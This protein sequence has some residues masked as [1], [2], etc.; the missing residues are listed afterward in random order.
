M[1]CQTVLVSIEIQ[2]PSEQVWEVIADFNNM[3][4]WAPS[5]EKTESISPV[6]R[7]VGAVRRN[8]ATGFGAID[9]TV[10]EWTE[11]EGFT[12]HVAPFGPFA[13][14]LTSYRLQ[15][16][17]ETTSECTIKLSY[18]LRETGSEG[19]TASQLQAKLTAGLHEI[20][21]A[22]KTRVETGNRI[23]E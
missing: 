5:I 2:K 19:P 6:K 17:S 3:H 13:S 4:T 16:L 20:L 1:N 23:R 9:Q 10:T 15:A 12:Y 7:G 21:G 22:L 14:T 8:T 18:S 11:G